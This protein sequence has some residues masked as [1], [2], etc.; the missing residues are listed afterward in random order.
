[1]SKI[2][3]SF[4]KVTKYMR[5]FGLCRPTPRDLSLLAKVKYDYVFSDCLGAGKARR[6]LW[7]GVRGAA[8][9]ECRAARAPGPRSARPRA[10]STPRPA[11]CPRCPAARRTSACAGTAPPRCTHPHCIR[12]FTYD[13]HTYLRVTYEQDV[14][15]TV[16]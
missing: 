4:S 8:R 6:C 12:S 14:C 11:T 16:C 15:L 9:A 13:I 7:R 1:M 3:L 10:A 2:H 5:C